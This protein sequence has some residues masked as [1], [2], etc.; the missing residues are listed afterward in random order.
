MPASMR[1]SSPS[2]IFLATILVAAC[3]PDEYIYRPAE[4]ATAE[5]GGLPAARYGVPPERPVGSVLVA[6]SG[7]AR[8]GF[9]GGAEQKMLQVRLVVSNNSDDAPWTLD[10]REQ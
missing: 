4:Q 5:V 7:L 2:G 8:I 9:S 1:A 6:S 10:T 3:A